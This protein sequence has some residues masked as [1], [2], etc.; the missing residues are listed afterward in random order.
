MKSKL[1]K[2]I[3]ESMSKNPNNWKGI[4]YYNP[5]D[6]RLVVR[7]VNPRMGWSFN[8]ASPYSY[9]TLGCII[10]ITIAAI[11]FLK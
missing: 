9:I 8:F 4:F 7:K 3:F 1:D 10:L 11:I 2:A 5:Q 6:P